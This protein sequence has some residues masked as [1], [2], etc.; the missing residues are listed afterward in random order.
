M[1]NTFKIANK[2]P[3]W[4]NSNAKMHTKAKEKAFKKY[5]VEGSSSAF[6]LY[7]ERNKKCKG[8]I[9]AAKI[10]HERHIAEE[11][12]KNPKK[13]FKYVNSKK[14]RASGYNG[15]GDC[16]GIEFI[17][18]LSLHKGIGELQYPKLQCLSS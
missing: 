13:F 17:L 6:R 11:S 15:W 1:G 10:E 8:A 5:K 18:L 4:L 3:G 14:G 7:K 12:K 16:K 2:S 9:K